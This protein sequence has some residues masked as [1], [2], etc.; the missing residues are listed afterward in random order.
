[1]FFPLVAEVG[2]PLMV[3]IERIVIGTDAL[4]PLGERDESQIAGRQRVDMRVRLVIGALISVP[5]SGITVKF[6]KVEQ[7]M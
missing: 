1:M 2:L 7:P 4:R 6:E 3:L 5:I